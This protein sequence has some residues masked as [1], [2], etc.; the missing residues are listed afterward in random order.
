[1]FSLLKEACSEEFARSNG[2][3]LLEP[4]LALH[5]FSHANWKGFPPESSSI[6]LGALTVELPASSIPFMKVT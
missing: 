6:D 2:T 1:M 4:Y 3:F 5:H